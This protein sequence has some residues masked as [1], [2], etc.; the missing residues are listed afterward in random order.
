MS[1]PSISPLSYP[2][3]F[4]VSSTLFQPLACF[5]G[6]DFITSNGLQ[7]SSTGD[8]SYFLFG[9]HCF[10]PLSPFEP[11]D[12]LSHPVD[13][14]CLDI[15]STDSP[16]C[17]QCLPVQSVTR[18]PVPVTSH[19]HICIPVRSEVLVNCYIPKS[20]KELLGMIT[21][22]I[23]SE[24]PS[25]LLAAYSVCQEQG[26]SI[27]VRLMNTS[28]VNI[29]LQAGQ[30]VSEFCPLVESYDPHLFHESD[31]QVAGNCSTMS[32]NNLASQLT[33]QIDPCLSD[34]RKDTILQTLLQYP[35]VFD[36][37]LG[38]TTVIEHRLDTGSYPPIRQYP[39]RFP[40]A[41]REE[42]KAQITDMLEQGVIQPSASPWALPIVLVKKKDGKY[43]FCIDYRKLNNVT[44]KDAHPLPRMDDLLDA[45]SNSQVF[46]TLDLRSEYWLISVA[47]EDRE[48]TAFI[49]PE[50]LW[51]FL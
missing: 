11:I 34:Q 33:A 23:S 37:S 13:S 46:S 29:E 10:T 5:L 17:S 48:K 41:Y 49:T 15:S 21:P 16:F 14:K 42:A 32:I 12:P 9:K 40:Y 18:G 19:Q 44:K 39:R 1:F 25:S 51:E 8:G 7:L 47:P 20:S 26:K 30:Q 38:H 3:T 50:S 6:W 24:F 45:L 28:N 22:V 36:E 31:N 2:G 27:V 4:L 35:D 43:R